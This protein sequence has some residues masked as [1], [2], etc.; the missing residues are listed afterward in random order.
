MKKQP[1]NVPAVAQASRSRRRKTGANNAI[2]VFPPSITSLESVSR[3]C[4]IV[5]LNAGGLAFRE[6]E[7]AVCGRGHIMHRR[8]RRSSRVS[9]QFVVHRVGT[10]RNDG[11]IIPRCAASDSLPP[12]LPPSPPPPSRSFLGSCMSRAVP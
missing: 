8:L 12:S 2:A 5:A 9:S 11:A 1:I 10:A 4:F 7:R 6:S 3:D